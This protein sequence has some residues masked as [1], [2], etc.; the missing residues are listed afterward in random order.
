VLTPLV[1]TLPTLFRARDRNRS[2]ELAVLLLLL[3]AACV[4]VF[5]VLPVWLD[6][7][8]FTVLPLIIWAAL[9]F[10]MSVTALSISSLPLQQRWRPH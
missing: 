7:L 3:I 10:G 8:T 6:I 4:I 1:L 9:R 2:I 5:G